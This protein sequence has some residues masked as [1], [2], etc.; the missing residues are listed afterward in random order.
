MERVQGRLALEG[1]NVQ[2]PA[3]QFMT[4]V[5]ECVGLRGASKARLHQSQ[6]VSQGF[7]VTPA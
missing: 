2:S 4:F 5:L 3:F 7:D 6:I 1:V